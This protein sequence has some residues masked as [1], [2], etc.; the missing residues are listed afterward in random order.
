V[1]N[2]SHTAANRDA[3]NNSANYHRDN[4]AW[5]RLRANIADRAFSCLDATATAILTEMEIVGKSVA[6]VCCNNGMELISIKKMGAGECVGFD[7]SSAFLDQARELVELANQPVKFV[8]AD[9]TALPAAYD[10]HFDLVVL[11]IGT[12][13]WFESLNPLFSSLRKLLRPGGVLFIYEMHP[14]LEMFEP[15][16]AESLCVTNDYFRTEPYVITKAITYDGSE[17]PGSPA[18]WF[19]HSLGDILGHLL[20]QGFK[21]ARFDEYPHNIAEDDWQPFEGKGL[22]LSYALVAT[23]SPPTLD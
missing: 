14:V 4:V 15:D 9:A 10:G 20:A 8:E 12:L 19:F 13:G 18:Y 21:L 7:I 11:T 1:G 16:A 23:S 22:P 5:A 3:W 6:H 17:H 2:Y